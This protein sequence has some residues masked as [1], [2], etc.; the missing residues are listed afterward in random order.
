METNHLIADKI[1][2][3]N[4]ENIFFSCISNRSNL[5][6]AM[7]SRFFRMSGGEVVYVQ[8]AERIMTNGG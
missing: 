8:A 4:S 5:L 7:L 2:R 6:G 3:I 1:R